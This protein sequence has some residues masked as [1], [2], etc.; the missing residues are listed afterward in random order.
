MPLP[1]APFAYHRRASCKSL[2][3]EIRSRPVRP[4]VAI[5]VVSG[6]TLAGRLAEWHICHNSV[7]R[8]PCIIECI[9]AGE[10]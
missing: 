10:R 6:I 2:K 4:R 5:F 1:L 3:F 9:S 8:M 7:R